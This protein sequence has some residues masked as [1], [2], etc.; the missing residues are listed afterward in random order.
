MSKDINSLL[1]SAISHASQAARYAPQDHKGMAN[2][3]EMYEAFTALAKA[4][5]DIQQRLVDVEKR[6]STSSMSTPRI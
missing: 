6:L 5:E 2:A 1:R 4:V 3:K